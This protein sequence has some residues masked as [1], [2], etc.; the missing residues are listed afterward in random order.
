M[1]GDSLGCVC[2]E[3]IKAVG[4]K[5]SVSGSEPTGQSN[6]FKET[7]SLEHQPL[8]EPYGFL[9]RQLR[10]ATG[11]SLGPAAVTAVNQ[12]EVGTRGLSPPDLES[13]HKPHL[14]RDF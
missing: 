2:L 11:R 14:S 13:G 4:T 8:C 9:W 5:L 7:F 10:Q 3:Q 1:V 6:M 12:Q